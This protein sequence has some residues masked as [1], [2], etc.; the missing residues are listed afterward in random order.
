MCH[1]NFTQFIHS[2]VHTESFNESDTVMQIGR[3]SFDVHLQEIMGTLMIG[4]TV[5]MLR[6]R[7]NLDFDY[8]ITI[9]KEKQT[10][11]VHS[12]PSVLY[13]FFTFLNDNNNW[14]VANCFR[15]ICS[16]GEWSINKT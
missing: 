1:R 11:Y 5:I 2:F 6:P 3:C 4:G 13:N 10:S 12:V 9:L 14:S 8:L 7:G 15:S 16:G